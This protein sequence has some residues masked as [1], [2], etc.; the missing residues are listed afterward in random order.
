MHA[1]LLPNQIGKPVSDEVTDIVQLKVA[2]RVLGQDL[3]VG[4]VVALLG[5]DGG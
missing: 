1:S 2:V 5:K 3:R 4:R